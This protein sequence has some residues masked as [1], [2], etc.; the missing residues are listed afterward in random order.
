ML[1][2]AQAATT[3]EGLRQCESGGN[4]TTNTGN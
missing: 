3:W 1:T 2:R 4:Y